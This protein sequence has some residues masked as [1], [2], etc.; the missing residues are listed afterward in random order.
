MKEA[1][2][3]QG[4]DGSEDKKHNIQHKSSTKAKNIQPNHFEQ[5]LHKVKSF[6][7]SF[8]HPLPL[9]KKLNAHRLL[10]LDID[11]DKIRYLIVKKYGN[12][13][14]VEEWGI[15]RLPN[16]LERCRYLWRILKG[17]FTNPAQRFV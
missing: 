9:L 5:K 8:Y 12:D 13:L 4:R 2:K 6:S 3:N 16:V 10:S 11:V 7:T 14:S 17:D 1:N 15:Q